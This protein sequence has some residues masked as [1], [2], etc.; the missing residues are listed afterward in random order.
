VSEQTPRERWTCIGLREGA[1]AGGKTKLIQGWVDEAGEER[2][3]AKRLVSYARAGQVYEMDVT[4]DGDVATVTI[5]GKNRPRYVRDIEH[6]ATVAGWE[7]ETLA[8]ETL[9]EAQRKA[10][11]HTSGFAKQL[12]P[13]RDQY[14][15]LGTHAKRAAFLARVI[16]EVT[17]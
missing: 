9:T 15:A 5:G 2:F 3:Y 12:A 17:A 8:A 4:R 16:E 14:R 10:L 11:S 7:A 6:A 1:T 13:V